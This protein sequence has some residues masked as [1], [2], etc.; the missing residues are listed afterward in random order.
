MEHLVVTQISNHGYLAVFVL[1][2]L[3]SACIPIPSEAV[4]LFAGALA[5]GAT[6]A[7]VHT[8]L[9]VVAV[10]LCGTAGNVAG[11]LIAYWV[12]RA[13][14]RPLIERWGRYVLLSRRELDRS[15]VFFAR[16]GPAAVLVGRV[17]P[18]IR[19]F[20]SLP[21]GV[22]EMP[23]VPF[24]GLTALGSL[25]WTFALAFAGQALAGNWA[26][27]SSAFTPVSI[28]IAVLIV[29][30]VAWWVLRRL[31]DRS[32]PRSTSASGGRGER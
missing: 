16:R 12:G 28:A 7:G 24:T 2:V 32:H 14:G 1:M 17:L 23:V 18:V 20:I 31:R 4:M 5:S 26:S 27:V 13:G 8:H 30:A 21:A 6:I 22:A 9:D 29:A 11:S 25:P 19:T 15:E 10:A 3:E